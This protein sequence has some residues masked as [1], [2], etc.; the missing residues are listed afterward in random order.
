MGSKQGPRQPVQQ[1]PVNGEVRRGPVGGGLRCGAG[2]AQRGPSEDSPDR[3]S[4]PTQAAPYSEPP[5]MG[6]FGGVPVGGG[7]RCGAG[8]GRLCRVPVNPLWGVWGV[9]PYFSKRVP[10]S[11]KGGRG[12]VRKVR[13]ARACRLAIDVSP[14]SGRGIKGVGSATPWGRMP[15]RSSRILDTAAA[16]WKM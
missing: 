7:S 6:R 14:S 13:L 11:S 3:G 8:R 2:R 1:P 10:V 16:V 12:P 5:S 4:R 9:Q 15:Y